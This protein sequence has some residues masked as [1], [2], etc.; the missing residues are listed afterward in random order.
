ML[1]DVGEGYSED[2]DVPCVVGHVLVQVLFLEGVDRR[3]VVKKTGKDIL[4]QF[5]MERLED[6]HEFYYLKVKSWS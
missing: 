4:I 3:K 1:C 2:G 6:L 5:V